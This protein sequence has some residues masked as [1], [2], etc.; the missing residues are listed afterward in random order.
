[1]SIRA[2][3][4]INRLSLW[5]LVASVILSK[6]VR[7]HSACWDTRRQKPKVMDLLL[8][9]KG[10]P[11]ANSSDTERGSEPPGG[12]PACGKKTFRW[13]GWIDGWKCEKVQS[14]ERRIKRAEGDNGVVKVR[15]VS[16]T[17]SVCLHRM[18]RN[19]KEKNGAHEARRKIKKRAVGGDSYW[20]NG[21]QALNIW[22]SGCVFVC[23]CVKVGSER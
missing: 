2:A 6:Y 3:W 4:W 11:V 1:M 23:V 13:M 12:A 5:L 22:M 21:E 7:W 19:G 16:A 10:N 9:E 17:F 14:Y 15:G 8:M 20:G 18:D